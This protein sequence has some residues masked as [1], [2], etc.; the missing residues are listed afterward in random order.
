MRK[1]LI[2]SVVALLAVTGQAVASEGIGAV[3]PQFGHVD[4]SSSD[5]TG[6]ARDGQDHLTGAEW[7][8]LLALVGG[9]TAIVV[10]TTTHH[11]DHGKSA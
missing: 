9:I 8:G 6:S 10:V 4:Y 1:I 3:A 5:R 11:H 2:A 7:A